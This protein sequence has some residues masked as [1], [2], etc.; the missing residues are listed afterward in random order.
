MAEGVVRNIV[1]VDF[2]SLHFTVNLAFDSVPMLKTGNPLLTQTNTALYFKKGDAVAIE[3]VNLCLPYQF[4]QGENAPSGVKLGWLDKDANAGVVTEFGS[5]G[6]LWIPDPNQNF[7]IE[8]FIPTP[9]AATNDWAIRVTA[10]VGWVNMFNVP[11][12]FDG[13]DEQIRL[14]LKVRSY[15]DQV[16]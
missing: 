10:I 3:S 11:A 13:T 2:I 8:S 1:N 14:F 5:D 12:A 15:F 16:V 6:T 4:G 9:A 7:K